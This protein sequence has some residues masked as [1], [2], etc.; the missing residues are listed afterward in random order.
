MPLRVPEVDVTDA[1]RG[2]LLSLASRRRTAQGP[3]LRARIVLACAEGVQNKEV[4]ARLDVNPNTVGKRQRRLLEQ[5]ID[6]LRDAPRSGAP[7]TIGDERVEAVITPTRERMPKAATTGS[8][9]RPSYTLHRSCSS[10]DASVV[11]RVTQSGF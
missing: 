2:E 7:C 9:P 6:G 10:P 4:A 8:P 1:E 11:V 3:A 5:R